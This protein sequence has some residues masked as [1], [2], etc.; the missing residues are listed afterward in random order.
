MRLQLFYLTNFLKLFKL[1]D[2]R[3]LWH[4]FGLERRQGHVACPSCHKRKLDT[5]INLPRGHS[6]EITNVKL[7]N[8]KCNKVMEDKIVT[9]A[10]KDDDKQ[11]ACPFG[12]PR[13]ACI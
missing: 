5:R 7:K 9:F 8:F 12:S 1:K 11:M 4:T 2:L 13:F 6:K 10:Q 3:I